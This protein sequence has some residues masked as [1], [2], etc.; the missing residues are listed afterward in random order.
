MKRDGER[1]LSAAVEAT[2]ILPIL[3]LFIV[4]L[5]SLAR[6]SLAQQAIGAAAGA[7]ARAASIERTSSAAEREARAAVAQT[8]DER[9]INCVQPKM[10]VDVAG[11]ARELGT[12]A[13]VTI[14]VSCKLSLADIALPMVPGDLSVSVTRT[15]PVD[16]WRGR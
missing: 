1:G 13:A 3:I 7:G 5:L 8:L 11:V 10:I 4:L 9:R 14:S 6:L 15:S 12:H 2:V 16:P